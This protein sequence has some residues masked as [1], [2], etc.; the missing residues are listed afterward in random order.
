MKNH[1]EEF[2]GQ[3]DVFSR[4]CASTSTKKASEALKKQLAL[5]KQEESET[6]PAW[7]NL[8]AA[9]KRRRV[10]DD[11]M[12]IEFDIAQH[13]VYESDFNFVKMHLLKHFSD[14]IHQL[15]NLLN[16]SSNLPEKARMDLEQAYW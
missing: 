11:T 9:A 15:G 10:D 16:V 12:Q 6:D 8:S 3:K 4:F 5:D 7:N 2:H 13:L 14:Y 1:L